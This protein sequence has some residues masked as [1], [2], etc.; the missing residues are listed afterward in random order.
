M[1]GG[2]LPIGKTI[3]YGET[4]ASL[5]SLY[6]VECTLTN[7]RFYKGVPDACTGPGTQTG[8]NTHTHDSATQAHTHS[9][10]IAAHTH[11]EPACTGGSNQN[12]R[13][14]G[15]AI[16]VSG[17]NH[18]HPITNTAGN[19]AS[20]CGTTTTDTAHTH[21]AV[22]HVPLHRELLPITSNNI[23]I[24]KKSLPVGSI[25][26]WLCSLAS[27]R[28]DFQVAD[29]TNGTLCTLDRYA[30]AVCGACTNPGTGAG[31]AS[32]QHAAQTH[33]HNNPFPHTHTNSGNLAAVAACQ[34]RLTG[35]SQVAGSPHVHAISAAS[36][37]DIGTTL[38]AGCHQHPARNNGP[39]STRVA[40]I[41]R[42]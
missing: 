38:A 37:C 26:I 33:T 16:C 27:I 13:Q 34:P 4:V 20:S 5:T 12:N 32:H 23:S 19:T 11:G 42:V 6:T 40:Y 9:Y 35:G 2:N 7:N 8:T 22:S 10:C 39:A 29:G 28:S 3:W 1:R 36:G 24:R 21:A 30:R 18:V 14:G 25:L 15:N 31:L 41:E 17:I